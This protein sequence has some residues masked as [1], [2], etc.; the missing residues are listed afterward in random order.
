MP[1]IRSSAGSPTG[2][3][4]GWVRSG[5][6]IVMVMALSLSALFGL[7]TYRTLVLL[8]SAQQLGMVETSSIRA[9]M[10]LQYVA[11]T[12]KVDEDALV[13]RLQLPAG[14]DRQA[15]LRLLA[16]K[17]GL[18]PFEYVQV[19]QV[20]IANIAAL[21]HKP[22]SIEEPKGWLATISEGF[23]SAVLVY[24]YPAL[25]LTLFLGAIGAPVPTGL[26]TTVAGSLASQGHWS[27]QW[28]IALAVGASVLGDLV[29]Y[30]LG[31]MVS[32][33]FLERYG[34]LFGYTSANRAR[35]EAMFVRWGAV[36]VLLTRT[37]ASH[38]SSVVSLLAGVSRFRLASFLVFAVVG[39][40]IWTAAYFE[41][42]Y[43]VGTDLEAASGF[44]AN[45][46]VFLISVAIVV[47]TATGLVRLGAPRKARRD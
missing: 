26:S 35:V 37:L 24:G 45:L 14:I 20:A 23:L 9:W 19:V 4:L 41:L 5:L 40:I 8:Q 10:T 3:R 15:T 18:S 16:E 42:G 36:A 44:L 27:W 1:L 12:Y 7:R 13:T 43:L 29:G 46:S 32:G 33:A 21:Q 38:L 25:A 28:T 39:R 22:G 2:L 34:R 31:R 11:A 17:Q 6:I 30:G 47:G